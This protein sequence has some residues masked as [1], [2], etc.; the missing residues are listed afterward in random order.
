ARRVGVGTFALLTFAL[1]AQS[2]HE[3]EHVAKIVEYIQ[4]GHKN[5]TGGILGIGPGALHPTFNLVLLHFSYN[6][7]AYTPAL[8]AFLRLGF[9]RPIL[10]G[11]AARRIARSQSR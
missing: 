10:D 5:G 3:L 6:T 8:L 2:W 9:H 7:L 1:V 4:L 11:L